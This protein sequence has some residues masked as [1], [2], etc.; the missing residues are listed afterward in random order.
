MLI[1]VVEPLYSTLAARLIFDVF[2]IVIYT[3]IEMF[4]KGA[5]GSFDVEDDDDDDGDD[6]D[7]DDDDDDDDT[8]RD[9]D[10]DGDDG[11]GDDD[12]ERQGF[13]NLNH[14]EHI[15]KKSRPCEVQLKNDL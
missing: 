9:D 4:H 8:G 12:D 14:Y 3:R 13:N 11:D 6:D 10:D 15:G 5:C 7:G 2:R 1:E